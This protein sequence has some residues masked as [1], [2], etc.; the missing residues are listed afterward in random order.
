M[1]PGVLTFVMLLFKVGSKGCE[2]LSRGEDGG[3]ELRGGTQMWDIVLH[4]V[5]GVIN[6]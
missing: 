2:T 4:G 3:S 6:A 5:Y 1:Q